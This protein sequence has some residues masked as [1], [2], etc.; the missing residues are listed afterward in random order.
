MTPVSGAVVDQ[1]DDDRRDPLSLGALDAGILNRIGQREPVAHAGG[2][3]ISPASVNGQSD[4]IGGRG[5]P[6]TSRYIDR[7]ASR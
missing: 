7:R 5:T 2:A 3:T 1:I 6:S 4:G